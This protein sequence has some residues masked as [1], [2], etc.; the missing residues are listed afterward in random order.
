MWWCAVLYSMVYLQNIKLILTGACE[1]YKGSAWKSYFLQSVVDFRKYQEF[2]SLEEMVELWIHLLFL[3]M[4]DSLRIFGILLVICSENCIVLPKTLQHKRESIMG[5]V[6][7]SLMNAE[8]SS[9]H[10]LFFLLFSRSL[11]FCE[12]VS[13]V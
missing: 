4:W 6:K 8:S 5:R 9:R 13:D 7:F 11:L 10:L 12:L 2:T 1:L 3:M